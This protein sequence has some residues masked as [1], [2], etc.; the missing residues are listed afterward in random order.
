MDVEYTTCCSQFFDPDGTGFEFIAFDTR[1]FITDKKGNPFLSY[2]EIQSVLSKSLLL[3]QNG[4]RGR[5]PR[6]IY[7]HKSTMF[8][9]D[10]VQGAR[11]AFGGKTEIELIQVVRS[12]DWFALRWEKKGRT[13]SPAAYPV[14][15]GVYLPLSGNECLLWT[16]GS[17]DGVNPQAA[18]PVF[19]DAAL[20]PLPS[21]I[22]VRRFA[23]DA[24]WHDTCRTILAMTK[25]D[26]NNNTLY[27]TIP[28][29]LVY[30]SIFADVVKNSTKIVDEV[31]D[32]RFFM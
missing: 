32:Y 18:R 17:V 21:P 14:Q 7:I 11:D 3:Y 16:Q 12:I 30:S 10:E 20:K 8:T 15:R 6:K 2:S 22:L 13:I 1:E 28:A 27:K 29:T 4:H 31:F 25:V 9:E 5:I 23:G 19:K 24:G 26:W